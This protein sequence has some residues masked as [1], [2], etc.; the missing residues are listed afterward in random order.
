MHCALGAS[1]FKGANLHG[2]ELSGSDLSYSNFEGADLRGAVLYMANFHSANLKGADL[3]DVDA[4][5]GTIFSGADLRGAILPSPD[6]LV[7]GAFYKTIIDAEQLPIIREAIEL[8]TATLQVGGRTPRAKKT[9]R[10]YGQFDVGDV[11]HFSTYMPD[12]EVPG[13]ESAEPYTP[14]RFENPRR[15][16]RTSNP[17]DRSFAAKAGN[18]I[19][20]DMYTY[21]LVVHCAQLAERDLVAAAADEGRYGAVDAE[22]LIERSIP[23]LKR[24]LRRQGYDSALTHDGSFSPAGIRYALYQVITG[25]AY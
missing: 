16:G 13:E 18:E 12:G 8:T 11:Q 22:E 4:A 7:G 1:K 21:E 25:N 20:D 15:A 17:V 19:L 9:P 14:G 5:G 6:R 2:A 10:T 3:S 24:A 23:I